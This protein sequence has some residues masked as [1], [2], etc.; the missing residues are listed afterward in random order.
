MNLARFL[1]GLC[2]FGFEPPPGTPLAEGLDGILFSHKKDT[3]QT[4]DINLSKNETGEIFNISVPTHNKQG[5]SITE[6][7]CRLS[8]CI[9]TDDV[10]NYMKKIRICGRN[11]HLLNVETR[12]T[13]WVHK[14]S[15]K[16]SSHFKTLGARMMTWKDP[17]N[18]RN[19]RK[20]F[21]RHGDLAP[22]ICALLC[23]LHICTYQRPYPPA[24]LC[25]WTAWEYL[26]FGNN[27]WTE[28][29]NPIYIYPG[30]KLN[31]SA[32]SI[33]CS[34]HIYVFIPSFSLTTK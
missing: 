15:K 19:N 1:E 28:C 26:R 27:L 8:W 32:V 17:T 16:F 31:D 21:R 7:N 2:N 5:T 25:I 11:G 12:D 20:K 18:I 34:K 14:S 33:L 13:S 23:Y 9:I 29:T 3:P 6:I 22:G 24:Y 10:E 30:K 4:C